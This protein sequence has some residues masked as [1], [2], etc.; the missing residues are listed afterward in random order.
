MPGA[1]FDVVLQVRAR[2]ARHVHCNATLRNASLCSRLSPVGPQAKGCRGALARIY[3]ARARSLAL[4]IYLSLF[5]APARSLSL[6]L[7]L[8]VSLSLSHSFSWYISLY[9]SFLLPLAFSLSV[10][11][12]RHVSFFPSLTRFIAFSSS[13][14][15]FLALV[16][17]LALFLSIFIFAC[18]L[19]I[20]SF[21]LIRS[22]LRA[23]SFS[24]MIALVCS[25][26]LSFAL[27]LPRL[28]ISL[29]GPFSRVLS[30]SLLPCV[31][32][33]STRSSLALSSAGARPRRS[34]SRAALPSSC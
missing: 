30:V 6:S 17:S 5:L 7:S 1:A 12:S 18:S 34:A 19:A 29:S 21:A 4:S 22:L 3:G 10:F 2:T 11:L 28:Y 32:R 20:H 27:F 13:R 14:A 15:L 26:S 8:C 24:L 16:L 9:F 33:R 31:A 23:R 25:S